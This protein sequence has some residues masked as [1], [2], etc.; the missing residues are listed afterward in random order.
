MRLSRIAS[1]LAD[2]LYD[3][4]P[5]V[6]SELVNRESPSSNSVKARRDLIHRML[7][8]EAVEHLGIEGFP[9][10]R[11]LHVALLSHVG[12]HAPAG[13]GTWRL[14]APQETDELSRTFLPLWDATKKLLMEAP[15]LL[16]VID[17]EKLWSQPPYGMRSGLMPVYFTAFVL[18]NR[19]NLAVYKDG[20]F[21]P[22]LTDADFDEYLQDTKRFSLRWIVI[23]EQKTEIL[24]A[25]AKV[26]SELRA[27]PASMDP[28]EAARGLVALVFALPAW[29][30]RTQRLS[31]KARAVRDTLLKAS[32]PHKVLFIDLP[33]VLDTNAG[34]QFAEELR[35]PVAELV[36]AYDELLRGIED[37]MLAELDGS[38]ED[39]ATLRA[40]AEM[41]DGISG[42][43]RQEAFCSRLAKH[44]G[45]RESME[46]ILSL[47]ANKP[48][49]D[50]ND[51]DIDAAKLEIAQAALRF[52]RDEAFVGVKGR[53]P[54]TEA[55][56]V[57]FGA[58]PET[59]TISR[60]FSVSEKHAPK[61]AMMAEKLVADLRS[62]G[63]GTD[64]MLAALANAG[65]QL[66]E[67]DKPNRSSTHG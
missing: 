41:L 62:Q 51:R 27:A 46:G 38:R 54:K 58:G 2:N 14:K 57:V 33:A 10:E 28:L 37:S 5:E 55:W 24:Q 25:V 1:E 47:S 32:D 3:K 45:G 65:M 53:K 4:A 39:F 44:D 26:L 13:D 61:V 9:A 64:L 48:P 20:V 63:L 52:R 8:H 17:I 15:A 34:T 59:R 56:A 36:T 66:T 60:A 29:T 22:E 43:L 23:D 30:Q 16:S 18:A 42:D 31:P 12:L 67:D 11:G 35:E 49:R 7:S 50:W 19:G 40:R 6:W 21:I